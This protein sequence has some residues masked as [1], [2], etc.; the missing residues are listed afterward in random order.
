M[1]IRAER[2]LDDEGDSRGQD[3][4]RERHR[5]T[6]PPACGHGEALGLEAAAAWEEALEYHPLLVNRLTAW[7]ARPHAEDIAQQ[8]MI[9]VWL[10]LT[11]GN[12]RPLA[13]VRA[14][15]TTVALNLR[16]DH[17]RRLARLTEVL[18]E[19]HESTAYEDGAEAPDGMRELHRRA[20]EMAR[21]LH[22]LVTPWEARVVILHKAYA[23]PAKDVAELLGTTTASVRTATHAALRKLRAPDKRRQVLYRFGLTD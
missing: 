15:M 6:E 18:V 11:D 1:A 3:N 23:L 8:T 20:A 13:S 2:P 7:E 22:G 14:W 5:T 17:R 9:K 12:A 16:R 4:E 21:D 10:H 19:D